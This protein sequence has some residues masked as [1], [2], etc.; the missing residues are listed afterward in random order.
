MKANL[1][2]FET[3]KRLAG[4][5]RG[6]SADGAKEIELRYLIASKRSVV[7]EFYQH[8]FKGQ[9]SDEM[10][11]V[12]HPSGEDLML[13]HYCT[14]GNQPRMIA[15]LEADYTRHLSFKYVSATNLTHH[16]CLRMSGV[17]FRFHDDNH[18]EQTWYWFGKKCY[19]DPRHHS[20]DY[21][22]LPDDGRPGEDMFLMVRT[23][24]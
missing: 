23:E 17:S 3:L 9:M 24:P 4:Q 19:V 12:Y 21:D 10:V 1:E 11:T 22:D 2:A 18:F 7:I 6:R 15:D 16:D 13:T 8:F 20:D 14:L 5:W